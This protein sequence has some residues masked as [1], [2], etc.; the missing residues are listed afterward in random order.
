[1]KKYENLAK[2]IIENVGGKE[3]IQS[4][5]H[6]VTRLRFQLVDEKK[7]NDEVLKNTEGIVT[8]MKSAGQYQVVIGNHVP[9][10]YSDICEIAQIG[11]EES[12]SQQPKKK[13]FDAM[14]DIVSS[15][16]QPIL[17]VM[18]AAGMLKGL[19]AL[20]VAIDLYS[21][22]G[23][24]YMFMNVLGDA[25][26]KFLPVFLGY[27][28]AKKFGLKPFIGLAIGVALC[29][30]TI[31]LGALSATNQPI[32]A[33]FQGTA[34]ESP[35]YT[36]IFGIPFI[37]MDYTS[38]VMPVIFICYIASKLEKL[39]EKL[40]PAMLKAFFV[41]MFTLF[42]ALLLGFIFIGPIATL[43]SNAVAYG[44]IAVRNFSPLLAGVLM[45]GFWQVLVIFG[46]HWGFIPIYIN[47]IATLGFDNVMVPF[48]AATFTQTAIVIAIMMK[49]KN[50]KM[51]EL[52]LP[53]AISAF[54]GITEP[55]IYGITL[56]KKKPFIISCVVSALVGGFYGALN[57]KEYIMGGLGIFEFPSFINPETN[58]FADL[59]VAA[60][61]VV[62]AM[63]LSFIL[64]MLLYKDDEEVSVKAVETSKILEREYIVQ[65]L[66]GEVCSLSD[67]EDNAFS[68]GILGK[69]LAIRPVNGLVKA[70]VTGKVTSIFP[71]YHALVITSDTG[72]EVLIHIGKD[73]VQLAGEYFHPHVKEGDQVV[74][75]QL[76]LEFDVESIEKAGYST[77]TPVV[78][79]NTA[80]F[81]DV[82][83]TGVGDSEEFLTVVK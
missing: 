65:P 9:D 63:I 72:V 77:M 70:P 24:T 8:V 76:L 49:T 5:T 47:N 2:I 64:T 33:L 44:I 19:N 26:F 25:F 13:L 37:A 45:G 42:F 57:L 35:I 66:E 32:S 1:M 46:V 38:T 30:P 50:K 75:G 14:I 74:A 61:G 20:F 39:A 67:V 41:P 16:F 23:G 12:P 40:I 48:F 18:S 52:C 7:A 73:T 53:A 82:L 6:C 28:A 81:L 51:K 21:A 22:D 71:T 69:G 10:V 60:I 80:K 31:Q 17:G 36:N 11:D 15:I 29:Y 79:L 56:P 59:Y 3:N 54:F 83:E 68:Q 55:A 43:A 34:F 78:V 62:V 27:T 58:S 4:L